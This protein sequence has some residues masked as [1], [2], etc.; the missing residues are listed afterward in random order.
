MIKCSDNHVDI[1]ISSSLMLQKSLNALKTK[2]SD[3]FE[4]V[5]R[6]LMNCFQSARYGPL[7]QTPSSQACHYALNFPL[8]THFTSPIRRYPDIIVHRMLSTTLFPDLKLLVHLF[9][10]TGG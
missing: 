10:N 7:S 4:C 5:L 8:Y 6:K 2:D 3:K 9:Y 1:D